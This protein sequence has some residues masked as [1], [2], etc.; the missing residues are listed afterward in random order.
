M[1]FNSNAIFSY[2]SV[3]DLEQDNV[4]WLIKSVYTEESFFSGA[5]FA[6]SSRQILH[7]L[8]LT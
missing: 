5:F 1:I 2:E 7:V 4:N 3:T 8:S 6:T